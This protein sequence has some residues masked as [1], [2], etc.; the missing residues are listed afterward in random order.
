MC[1][2]SVRGIDFVSASVIFLIDFG[3]VLTLTL[4]FWLQ[5]MCFNITGVRA[6]IMVFSDTFNNI[7]VISWWSA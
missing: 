2:Y 5:Y 3:T 1:V 4:Y 7:S 6:M